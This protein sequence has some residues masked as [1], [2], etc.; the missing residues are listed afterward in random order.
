MQVTCKLCGAVEE[1]SYFKEAN[2]RLINAQLCFTCGFWMEK[3]KDNPSI[4]RVGHHHYS[5]GPQNNDP[6]E[7]KGCGGRVFYIKFFDGRVVKTSNLWCQ[8][9]I[10]AHFH[11]LLPDNANFISCSEWRS[12]L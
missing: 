2:D 1:L 6:S 10:P 7:L 5:I 4:V 3:V 11:A 9:K 12:L 8:G